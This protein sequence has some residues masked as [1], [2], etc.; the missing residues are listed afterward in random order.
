MSA[1]DQ[2][3]LRLVVGELTGITEKGMK[4]LV[5]RIDRELKR[6]TPVDTGWARAN[7]LPSIGAPI[8]GYPGPR[9]GGE[10]VAAAVSRAQSEQNRA[11]AEI[12]TSY[13]LD[14]GPIWISNNVPYVEQLNE[15]SST[16]AP[17]NFISIAIR[18]AIDAQGS[19]VLRQE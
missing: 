19:G 6:A 10:E 5:L 17:S 11:M 9:P 3:Q 8:T 15:G 18:T 16:Q 12:A 13:T 4:R 1:D 7:W 14:K 2:Q